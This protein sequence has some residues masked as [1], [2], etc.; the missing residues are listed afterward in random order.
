MGKLMNGN[1]VVPG[2]NWT[3]RQVPRSWVFTNW[4]CQLRALA[5]GRQISREERAG[6]TFCSRTEPSGL[7]SIDLKLHDKDLTCATPELGLQPNPITTI[8]ELGLY[9]NP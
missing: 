5:N 9:P 3:A 1:G 4:T 2:L 8:C 6:S 7:A